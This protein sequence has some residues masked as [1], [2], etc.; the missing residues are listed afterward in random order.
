MRYLCILLCLTATA[1][2]RIGEEYVECEKRIG[3][4][5]DKQTVGK[6]V[7]RYLHKKGDL[8]I[9]V[10]VLDG[11]SV[12]ET[13]KPVSIIEA[14]A[15]V[16]QQLDGAFKP[17]KEKIPAVTTWEAKGFHRAAYSQREATLV[18]THHELTLW[19]LKELQNVDRVKGL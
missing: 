15:I 4:A 19:A 14:S 16:E 3:K 6:N 18:I 12:E 8:F 11:K 5:Y 7:I 13:Y 9:N 10:T 17:A 1:A 2:A